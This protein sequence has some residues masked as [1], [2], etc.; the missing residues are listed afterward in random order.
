MKDSKYQRFINDVSFVER[1]FA[2]WNGCP[3]ALDRKDSLDDIR[4]R[5]EQIIKKHNLKK[6]TDKN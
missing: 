1:G 3:L 5:I 4:K 2:D 6:V